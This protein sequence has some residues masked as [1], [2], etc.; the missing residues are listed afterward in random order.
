MTTRSAQRRKIEDAVRKE[1]EDMSDEDFALWQEWYGNDDDCVS[2]SKWMKDDDGNTPSNAPQIK[3][4]L[5]EA[6]PDVAVFVSVGG[7]TGEVSLRKLFRRCWRKWSGDRDEL[8]EFLKKELDY[9]RRCK[10]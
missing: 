6:Y 9:I 7:M 5:C 8:K 4:N 10:S 2:V 3:L 1:F